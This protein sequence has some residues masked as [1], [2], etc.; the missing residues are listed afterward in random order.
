MKTIFTA[1]TFFLFL[2]FLNAQNYLGGSDIFRIGYTNSRTVS[3]SSDVITLGIVS[4]D[5]TKTSGLFK[6]DAQAGV[7]IKATISGY[8]IKTRANQ[9]TTIERLYLVDVTKYPNG[10][11]SLPIEGTLFDNF[12]LSFGNNV[13]TKVELDVFLLKKRKDSD[14]SF[15][16]KNISKLTQNLPFP[17]NPFDPIVK[18]FTGT[19]SD[20]LSPE[21]DSDNNIKERI[22]TGKISLNFLP[23]SPFATK[24]GVFAIIFGAKPPLTNGF[25]DI[26][27]QNQYIL[28]IVTEPKRVIMVA[29]KKTPNATNELKNDNLMFY[30]TAYSSN[31]P[32]SEE[33]TTSL[34]KSDF[35]YTASAVDIQNSFASAEWYSKIKPEFQNELQVALEKYSRNDFKLPYIKK[36]QLNN[37]LFKINP[38]KLLIM[39]Y[40]NA[41]E[42]KKQLGLESKKVNLA[43][44]SRNLLIKE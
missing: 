30:V 6:N 43:I 22:P 18:T 27:K 15:V 13:Y 12:K 44:S 5:L 31:A 33:V 40:I 8:D 2:N 28:S 14:F 32:T 11:V 7:L 21:N 20:M 26:K 42:I 4:V 25:I 35:E 34:T 36:N 3:N 38:N 16:L 29:N 10:Q 9:S 17:T 23:N 41:V 37:K 39:D 1:I 24:T 19:I